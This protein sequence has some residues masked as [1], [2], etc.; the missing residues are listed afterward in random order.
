MP[1]YYTTYIDV[2]SHPIQSLESEYTEILLRAAKID[3]KVKAQRD[4]LN[5]LINNHIGKEVLRPALKKAIEHLK[6]G[7]SALEGHIKGFFIWP[8]TIENHMAALD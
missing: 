1:K 7:R 5:S 4:R 6:A 8:S 2:A 3:I